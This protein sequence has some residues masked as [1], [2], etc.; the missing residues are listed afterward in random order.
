MGWLVTTSDFSIGDDTGDT[1][2]SV[3][4]VIISPVFRD[5]DGVTDTDPRVLAELSL[6]LG[7]RSGNKESG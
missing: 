2:S 3:G 6:T 7:T 4:A 1:E 5:S